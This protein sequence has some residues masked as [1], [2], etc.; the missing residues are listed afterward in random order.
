M[1]T[2]A[3]PLTVTDPTMLKKIYKKI[4]KN[5]NDYYSPLIDY[6][7]SD[8]SYKIVTCDERKSYEKKST[9]NKNQIKN[10]SDDFYAQLYSFKNLPKH[11][12]FLITVVAPIISI[13]SIYL[14]FVAVRQGSDSLYSAVLGAVSF[15]IFIICRDKNEK[16]ILQKQSLIHNKSFVTIDEVRLYWIR[17][18]IGSRT[19]ICEFVKKLSEWKSLKDKYNRNAKIN[20]FNYIYDPQSKPRILALFIAF[21][22]LFTVMTINTFEIEPLSIIVIFFGLKYFLIE[23]TGLVLFL[24]LITVFLLWQII[25]ISHMLSRFIIYLI[26]YLNRDNLSELRFSI[27][28]NFLL[29]HVKF[30][31]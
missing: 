5:K 12:I 29:D 24:G 25:F 21:I 17:D 3:Y 10:L 28:M 11:Y 19:D 15:T 16:S 7:L 6:D 2:L 22:S 23:Q 20:W 9:V 13:V 14:L 31:D 30:Y 1:L 4:R 26:D 18:K 27:L 8:Y